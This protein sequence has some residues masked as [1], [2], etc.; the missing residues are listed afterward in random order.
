MLGR[1]CQ[2]QLQKFFNFFHRSNLVA[3]KHLW[4]YFRG[5]KKQPLPG[6]EIVQNRL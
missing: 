4:L 6:R 5:G 2:P 3:I 1:P